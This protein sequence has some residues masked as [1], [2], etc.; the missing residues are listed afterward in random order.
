[1]PGVTIRFGSDGWLAGIDHLASPNADARPAGAGISLVVIHN[2]SLPPGRYGEGHVERLFTNRPIESAHGFLER[3]RDV[4]VSAH[5]FLDRT[6]RATQFVSCLQ[7]AWHAGAS[8]FRGRAHCND[9]SIGIE[10]E[11]SD[12]EPYTEAQYRT[13]NALLASIVAA[14]PVQS[15]VGHSDIASGRKTDPGPFFRWDAL[16]VSSALL[17]R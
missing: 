4:R 7:R 15:I 16:Q 5:F 8:R 6:G 1:M 11:G 17:A 14:Y 3:I 9:F 12:F 2:I 10:L 13:L